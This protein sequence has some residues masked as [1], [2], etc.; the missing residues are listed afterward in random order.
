MLYII[1]YFDFQMK[2]MGLTPDGRVYT[3][4]FNACALSPHKTSALKEVER[5]RLLM[6]QREIEAGS[7]TYL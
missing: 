2:K 3:S 4:L 7:A 1:N 6:T 5:L